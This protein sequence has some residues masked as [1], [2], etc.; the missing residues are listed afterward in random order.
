M[1]ACFVESDGRHGDIEQ[2]IEETKETLSRADF[3]LPL[4][5]ARVMDT[6]DIKIVKGSEEQS[7]AQ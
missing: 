2:S 5:A 7:E 3:F 1:E 6:M 4:R